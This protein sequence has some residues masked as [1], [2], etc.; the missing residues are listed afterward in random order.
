MSTPISERIAAVVVSRLEGI[1]ES[2][3]YSF[4]V[5]EVVRPDRHGEQPRYKHLSIIVDQSKARNDA[6]DIPGN[7]PGVGFDITFNLHLICRDGGSETQAR[8]INDEEMQA[9]VVRAVTLGLSDWYTMGGYAVNSEFG[10]PE[11]F[12]QTDGEVA[13]SK[14]PLIVTYRVSEYDHTVQR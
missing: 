14:Y 8:A 2:N 10:S 5:S 12:T 6:I 3:G 11:L 7:P 13:G 4:D 1:T 9:E